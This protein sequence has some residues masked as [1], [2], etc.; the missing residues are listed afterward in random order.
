MGNCV[1]EHN[2]ATRLRLSARQQRPDPNTTAIGNT[3]ADAHISEAAI[4]GG[5]AQHINRSVR[6]DGEA[7]DTTGKTMIGSAI[8]FRGGRARTR[9]QVDLVNIT[10]DLSK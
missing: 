2:N 1:V 5:V 6:A 4:S 9:L 3:F 10:I 7:L 8:N